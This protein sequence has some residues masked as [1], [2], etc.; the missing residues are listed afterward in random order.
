MFQEDD[1]SLVPELVTRILQENRGL[2]AK[3]LAL[4]SLLQ[5]WRQEAP[6][7]RVVVVSCSATEG[8]Q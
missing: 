2:S 5:H 6:D 8:Q 3:S 1:Q 4:L 7:D